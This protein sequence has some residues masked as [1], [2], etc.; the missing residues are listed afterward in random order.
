MSQPDPKHLESWSPEDEPPSREEACAYERFV[1]VLMKEQEGKIPEALARKY[2][3]LLLDADGKFA[4]RQ[5]RTH[6]RML[7]GFHKMIQRDQI[8][9]RRQPEEEEGAATAT[10]WSIHIHPP[11]G[12]EDPDG[13]CSC[14]DPD[15]KDDHAADDPTPQEDVDEDVA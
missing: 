11:T 3:N 15:C 9:L 7:E 10:K 13:T 12:T 1:R 5:G 6:A 2:L 14:G 8:E 4:K